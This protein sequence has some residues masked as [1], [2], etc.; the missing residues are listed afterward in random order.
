MALV[1]RYLGAFT[2]GGVGQ[3]VLVQVKGWQRS[4]QLSMNWRMAWRV[5]MPKKISPMFSQ[6][7]DVGV[8]CSIIRGFADQPGVDPRVLV[9]GV[10]VHHD[11]QFHPRIGLGDQF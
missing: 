4:F 2:A 7:P 1:P 5:M 11:V 9:G 10:V 3:A 6:D 8:R